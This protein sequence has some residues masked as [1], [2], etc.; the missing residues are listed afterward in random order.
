[1]VSFF[2]CLLN[3]YP[4]SYRREYGEEMLGVLIDVHSEVK[5]RSSLAQAISYAR[6]AGGLLRGAL[7]EHARTIFFLKVFL[8]IRKGGSRCVPNT[9]FRRPRSA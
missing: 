3:L 9:S 4:A 2:R 6:E 7:R 5:Q 1:M 8:F